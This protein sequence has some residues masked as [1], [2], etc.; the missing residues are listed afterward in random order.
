MFFIFGKEKQM[1]NIFSESFLL[2]KEKKNQNPPK[3]KLTT[4]TPKNFLGSF[5]ETSQNAK[6]NNS[7]MCVYFPHAVQKSQK[8]CCIYHLY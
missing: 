4:K 6:V 5:S 8:Q 2:Q 1:S 3:R 7:W